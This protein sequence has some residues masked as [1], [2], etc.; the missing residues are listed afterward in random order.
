[1]HMDHYNTT[2]PDS[3][4]HDSTTS[5]PP[6]PEPTLLLISEIVISRMPDELDLSSKLLAALE[7]YII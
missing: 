1:M 3:D 5:I 4:A 6:N 7:P 2:L